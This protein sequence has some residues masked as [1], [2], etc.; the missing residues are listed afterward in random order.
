MWFI[1]QVREEQGACHVSPSISGAVGECTGNGGTATE[2]YRDYCLGW[3]PTTA[4]GCVP[5]SEFE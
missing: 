2:D 1:L 5:A 4:P 3:R